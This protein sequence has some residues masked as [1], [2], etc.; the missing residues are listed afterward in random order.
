M[1]TERWLL[2]SWWVV[3]AIELLTGFREISQCVE[4]APNKYY[5]LE[6]LTSDFTVKN[7]S[8]HHAKRTFSSPETYMR[9]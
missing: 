6:V 8:R 7:S 3:S 2:L 9:G 1:K 5:L 4:K